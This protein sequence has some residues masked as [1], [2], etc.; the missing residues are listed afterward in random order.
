M[1]R[2][3]NKRRV[4][5]L[6]VVGK[7]EADRYL[8]NSLKEFKRLCDD[9]EIVCNN[10]DPKTEQMIRRYGYGVVR[11]DRE[12]GI[13]QPSIKTDLLFRLG[14]KKPDVIL[15]LDSDEVFDETFT[16]EKL[17][18]YSLK[19]PACYFYIVNLWN[20]EQHQR[21]SLGFWNIRMFNWK[22]ELG[23]QYIKK[24]LHCGLGPPWTYKYGSYVPFYV[25][26]YGLMT[27]ESRDAKVAR[28]DKFDPNARWKD[29]AYYDALKTITNGSEFNEDEMRQK[30]IS[31][32]ARMGSQHKTIMA[33]D[34]KQK[35]VYVRRNKDGA[36][37]EIP[38][39][40]YQ[41]TL[42]QGFT[43]VGPVDQFADDIEQLFDEVEEPKVEVKPKRNAK[44]K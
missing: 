13:H 22:P 5:G 36:I 3:E 30:L 35:F 9:A 2:A 11:D 12:W 25:K 34:I 40:N 31:E 24:N 43:Y 23:N 10:T 27:Q 15:P 33:K 4:I 6:M 38:E 16:R 32:V 19:F 44:K 26:H 8:E 14:R 18:E 39:K 20:D 28:Y 7:G 17:E 42:K 1:G 37:L 21:K 41:D 29:R